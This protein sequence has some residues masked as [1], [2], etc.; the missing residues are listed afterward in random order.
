MTGESLPGRPGNLTPQEQEKLKELWTL[1]LRLSGV[2][3]TG[4]DIPNGEAKTN[5]NTEHDGSHPDKKVKRKR[6]ASLRSK[7]KADIDPSPATESPSSEAEDKHGQTKEYLA[8][9]ATLSPE[10][11][12]TAYW[13]MLK[14]DNPDA[15]LLRFLRARKWDV[16]KA[17]IMM[18]STLRWR[19]EVRVDEDTMLHGELGALEA[20][21]SSDPTKRK[22]GEEFLSQMRLGKSFLHGVDMEHRPMVFVRARLHKSS[23]QC[24]ETLERFTIYVIETARLVLSPPVDTA[25]SLSLSLVETHLMM[26]KCVVFDMTGFGM[27]NMVSSPLGPLGAAFLRISRTMLPSNS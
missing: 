12:R 22:L 5:G 1:T 26:V 19:L 18:I 15:L 20:S 11:I 4:Q 25:V 3:A 13:A 27:A 17:L 14:L 21:E 8:A 2:L 16:E 24:E 6:F 23:D 7:D 9:I 10:Q